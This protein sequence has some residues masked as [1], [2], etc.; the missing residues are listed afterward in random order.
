MQGQKPRKAA[1]HHLTAR[2]AEEEA[3]RLW[4][5]DT[6]IGKVRRGRKSP[7]FTVGFVDL[8]EGAKTMGTSNV[9]WE[10]AFAIATGEMQ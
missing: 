6:R 5:N 3:H 7:R 4:G 9:D 8:K 10:S 1:P 2:Q